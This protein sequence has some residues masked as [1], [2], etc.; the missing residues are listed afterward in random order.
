MTWPQWGVLGGRL[1]DAA[2]LK[3]LAHPLVR[4]GRGDAGAVT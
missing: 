4:G 1:Y 2:A 3:R